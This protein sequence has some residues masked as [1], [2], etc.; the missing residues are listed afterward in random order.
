MTPASRYGILLP[1]S[2]PLNFPWPLEMTVARDNSQQCQQVADRTGLD[3]GIWLADAP[4]LSPVF[5]N[6]LPIT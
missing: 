1:G 2:S 4:P 5:P 3:P 6:L